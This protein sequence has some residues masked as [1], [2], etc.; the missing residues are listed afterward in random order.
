MH[1]NSLV[2]LM[3]GTNSQNGEW[4]AD[5]LYEYFEYPEFE[6]VRPHRGVRTDRYKLIWYHALPEYP[7]LPE[8]FELY[9]LKHDPGEL[10]NLYGQPGYESLTQELMGRIAVLRKETEDQTTDAT[11]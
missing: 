5:W 10:T 9:D 6:H 3:R 1:G 7:D 2:P 11:T 8:E 4:R